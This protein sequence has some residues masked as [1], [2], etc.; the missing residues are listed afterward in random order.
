MSCTPRCFSFSRLDT[1]W[2]A[3]DCVTRLAL[4]ASEKLRIRA[5]S[6]NTFSDWI[7]M[8]VLYAVVQAR[9]RGFLISSADCIRCC[10]TAAG[11]SPQDQKKLRKLPHLLCGRAGEKMRK[12]PCIRAG[13][14]A[15]GCFE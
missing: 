15:G 1:T 2:L 13:K 11:P 14:R 4:A 10:Y 6:Q 7:C 5:T 12:K 3:A 8:V 9:S